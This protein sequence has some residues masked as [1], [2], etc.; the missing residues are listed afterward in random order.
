MDK[1]VIKKL[2]KEAEILRDEDFD[3]KL[4]YNSEK[5]ALI[6]ITK[7]MEELQSIEKFF[8]KKLEDKIKEFI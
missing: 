3:P 1:S 5:E 7:F 6:W 4:L 8:T 2:I